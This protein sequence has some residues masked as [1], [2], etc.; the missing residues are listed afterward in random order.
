MSKVTHIEDAN[1]TVIMTDGMVEQNGS[2]PATSIPAV[3]QELEQENDDEEDDEDEDDDEDDDDDSDFEDNSVVML[4]A[5]KQEQ[6]ETNRLSQT[7]DRRREKEKEKAKSNMVAPKTTK[8]TRKPKGETATDEEIQ[9]WKNLSIQCLTSKDTM[10]VSTAYFVL[11][12]ALHGKTPYERIMVYFFVVCSLHQC[13]CFR[14]VAA[15]C[16]EDVIT[17]DKAIHDLMYSIPTC[18]S[19]MNAFTRTIMQQ[20]YQALL[21]YHNQYKEKVRA[22]QMKGW[23]ANPNGLDKDPFVIN[24]FMKESTYFTSINKAR[25]VMW[26]LWHA[27]PESHEKDTRTIILRFVINNLQ[28]CKTMKAFQDKA[29]AGVKHF[30]DEAKI[31]QGLTPID[32]V[33]PAKKRPTADKPKKKQPP[34]KKPKKQL[35]IDGLMKTT[36]TVAHAATNDNNGTVMKKPAMKSQL[37]TYQAIVEQWVKA[38][39]SVNVDNPCKAKWARQGV[40]SNSLEE[41]FVKHHGKQKVILEPPIR[42]ATKTVDYTKPSEDWGIMAADVV[43]VL[44]AY[45]E[46]LEYNNMDP[47]RWRW[48]EHLLQRL[49]WLP[50][51]TTTPP[52]F[53]ELLYAQLVCITLAAATADSSCIDATKRLKDSGLL[54]PYK[55]AEAD[56]ELI[57]ACIKYCGID[58]LRAGYLKQQAAIIVENDGR[59]HTTYEELTKYKGIARKSILLLL[60]EGLNLPWGVACDTHV[61]NVMRAIGLYIPPSDLKDTKV[62]A[63]HVEHSLRSWASVSMY[64]DL[65]KIPGSCA[66]HWTQEMTD[67][68]KSQDGIVKLT[69][70]CSAIRERFSIAYH[71]HILFF[72]LAKVINF[73]GEEKLRATAKAAAPPVAPIATKVAAP[74]VAAPPVAAKDVEDGWCVPGFTVPP[75]SAK[76]REDNG[77]DSDSDDDT[78]VED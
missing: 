34:K 11:L 32:T 41:I 40:E 73:Y 37:T 72:V 39:E 60:T 43:Y 8:S 44:K 26:D 4:D 57:R 6:Q 15:N 10:E 35:Q 70:A 75:I 18:P 36:I 25:K 63:D 54:N 30:L 27:H 45:I 66:Q 3:S 47:V 59:V 51:Q 20:S 56:E 9:A 7:L 55:M 65:N 52:T 24:D 69:I 14:F 74:P 2:Y 13:H 42:A 33:F 67:I 5:K 19:K 68:I 23:E 50:S 48:R 61:M 12:N 21:D 64:T 28:E 78:V 53:D 76:N 62:Y 22:L 29:K 77:P 38:W 46:Q 16:K 17:T 31:K 1:G 58:N 49:G 71:V